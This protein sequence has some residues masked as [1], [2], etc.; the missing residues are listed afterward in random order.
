MVNKE[1]PR[2]FMEVA[3][4]SKFPAAFTGVSHEVTGV[5]KNRY[6][7]EVPRIL[8]ED[9]GLLDEV[10]GLSEVKSEEV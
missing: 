3:G 1:F 6:H 9:L 2:T 4:I 7:S 10:I 5:F 8:D